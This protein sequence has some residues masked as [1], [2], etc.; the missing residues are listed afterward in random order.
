LSFEL[1][2][3]VRLKGRRVIVQGSTTIYPTGAGN[4]AVN[5]RFPDLK[6]VERVLELQFT[7]APICDPG[8]PVNKVY[9][10]NI[11]GFTLVGVATGTTLTVNAVAVGV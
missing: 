3:V 9:S 4:Y 2:F 5:V 10:G 1:P 8:S 11:V 6:H 7:T